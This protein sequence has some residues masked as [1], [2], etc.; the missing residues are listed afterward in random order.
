VLLFLEKL[1]RA[2]S[3]NGPHLGFSSNTDIPQYKVE[4]E[5][6]KLTIEEMNA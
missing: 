3:A 5:R 1:K 2:L 4:D 6:K